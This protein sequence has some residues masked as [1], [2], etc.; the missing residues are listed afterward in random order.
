MF[1]QQNLLEKIDFIVNAFVGVKIFLLF[2]EPEFKRT[3]ELFV[4]LELHLEAA[5]LHRFVEID[6][7]CAVF[8]EIICV[9]AAW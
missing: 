4:E 6:L 5:D 8:H 3:G 1:N 2:E 7:D 9:A